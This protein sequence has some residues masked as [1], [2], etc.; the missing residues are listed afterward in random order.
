MSTQIFAFIFC[1]W[2]LIL[3]GGGLMVMII[4]PIS[5][6][7]YGDIDPIINSGIK[8]LIALIL[9]FIWVFALTK[10]KNWIFQRQASS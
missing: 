5:F 8:V 9:I 6:T 7:G 1:M 3:V 2:V 4:G 10:I